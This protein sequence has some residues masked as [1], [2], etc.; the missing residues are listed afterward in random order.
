MLKK[1]PETR[2]PE[3]VRKK[4]HPKPEYV[5]YIR[6]YIAFSGVSRFIQ[7]FKNIFLKHFFLVPKLTLKRT[8]VPKKIPESRIPELVRKK[9]HPKP[10][11][12]LY[13]CI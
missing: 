4:S 12:L 1:I 6:I 5:V 11:Y 10:E 3:L 9:S 2:I 8:I 13:I 7:I